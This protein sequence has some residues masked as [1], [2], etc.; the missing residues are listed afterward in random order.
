MPVE[1]R[2]GCMNWRSGSVSDFASGIPRLRLILSRFRESA[3]EQRGRCNLRHEL[4]PGPTRQPGRAVPTGWSGLRRHGH[5]RAVPWLGCRYD[6][7]SAGAA[8]GIDFQRPRLA[9]GFDRGR[10]S[11]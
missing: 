5:D 9:G 3:A 4:A 1:R 2:P 7:L 11:R 6:W 8:S 10:R